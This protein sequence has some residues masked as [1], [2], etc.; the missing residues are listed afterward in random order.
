MSRTAAHVPVRGV[1]AAAVLE[2]QAAVLDKDLTAPP[3]SPGVGD[4]Y[5]VAS[6]ATGD[7]ATHEDDIAEWNG[8]AWIF[9]TP[10]AGWAVYVTDEKEVY[11]F[12][13]T[14]WN[15]ESF[16]PH[17]V[18]HKGG[19]TDEIDA[20]TSTLAGL[21]SAVDKAK[22]D[23]LFT[24]I[25][26]VDNVHDILEA[27]TGGETFYLEDGTHAITDVIT[28]SSRKGISIFGSRAAIIER[29]GAAEIFKVE[30]CE[31]FTAEGF[32][33]RAVLS[34]A[35]GKMV[36]I[37]RAGAG[38]YTIAT[39]HQWRGLH[40]EITGAGQGYGWEVVANGDFI[41]SV[42]EGCTFS[43]RFISA[44]LA[45]PTASGRKL[46]N[47]AIRDNICTT[48]YTGTTDP[49]IYAESDG[50]NGVSIEG[51]QIT[52][53]WGKGI[54]GT[55]ADPCEGWI[56]SRNWIRD[57]ISHGID[58]QDSGN[59]VF[60]IEANI[61]FTVGGRGIL[62]RGDYC[63]ISANVIESAQ[64]SAIEVT[65]CFGPVVNDNVCEGSV[66]G[67]GIRFVNVQ[68]GTIGANSCDANGGYGI[69]LTS[70]SSSNTLGTNNLMLNS[71]GG[72]NFDFTC[73]DNELDGKIL[74]NLQTTDATL[75]TIA[76][77][78]LADDTV[79]LLEAFVVGRQTNA[80]A[81]AGYIRRALFYREAAGGVAQQG[82]INTEFT[83][84]SATLWNAT[85]AP[86][87]NNIL[88]QVQGTAGDNVNW[89]CRYKLQERS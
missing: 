57:T 73:S 15:Q 20:A 48:T 18:T 71:S 51:N 17:A 35:G 9:D 60:I 25:R 37:D 85:F 26:T 63:R 4:R 2:W 74:N 30:G 68:E 23:G 55:S 12:D 22:F 78:P 13:G 56:V 36:Q 49:A 82:T 8:V 84:E 40:F 88:I 80:A 83:R 66:A 6:V 65:N 53:P 52:G 75:T 14:A 44:V 28:I 21:M 87:G 19:G 47:V 34:A 50:G 42:I 89:E 10:A 59:W 64:D 11:F 58:I 67:D 72:Y 62:A 31:D 79:A 54:A 77:I 81:R 86:S 1:Q 5:I 69:S 61:I 46:E 7:W 16:G 45:Q 29:T 70:T 39:R 27:A 24:I 41:N 3:G 43:G 76:T 32:T 38:S 33:T